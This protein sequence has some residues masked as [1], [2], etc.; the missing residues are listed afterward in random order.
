MASKE[1]QTA[2][3]VGEELCTPV[4]RGGGT[5]ADSSRERGLRFTAMLGGEL[6]IEIIIQ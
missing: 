1:M 5:Y 4:G 3:E 6:G 2:A